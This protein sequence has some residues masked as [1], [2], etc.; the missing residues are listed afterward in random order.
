[1]LLWS[2]GILDYLYI[3]IIGEMCVSWYCPT[4][5]GRKIKA[6]RLCLPA[7]NQGRSFR[8][9]KVDISESKFRIAV[10]DHSGSIE[11]HLHMVRYYCELEIRA[12]VSILS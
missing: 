3:F 4:K 2:L 6:S 1:M 11:N 7:G 8:S 5:Q 9:H 12:G 10:V